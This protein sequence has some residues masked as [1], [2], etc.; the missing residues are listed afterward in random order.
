MVTTV[1][2]SVLLLPELVCLAQQ[3]Y[4]E[5]WMSSSEKYAKLPEKKKS[6]SGRMKGKY[7]GSIRDISGQTFTNLTAVHPTKYRDYKGSVIWACQCVCKEVAYVSADNLISGNTKSCGCLK[8]KHNLNMNTTLHFID[9]TCVE[10]LEK[11]KHRS[12][13][14]SGFR[15]VSKIR[16]DRFRVTI[17]FKGKNYHRGYF[18]TLEEAIEER[19]KA[20]E[21]LYEPFIQEFYASLGIDDK[22]TE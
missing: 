5:D 20:E 2:G 11:R 8:D 22:V 4:V 12:D 3:V 14:K 15:G 10:W 6:E 16:D 1:I 7:G 13:N 17:G 19:L 9:G 18:S 21:E